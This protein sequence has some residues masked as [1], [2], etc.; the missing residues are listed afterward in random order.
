MRFGKLTR[1]H[2]HTHFF[3]QLSQWFELELPLLPV[4]I[5]ESSLE[6]AFQPIFLWMETGIGARG[7]ANGGNNCESVSVKVCAAVDSGSPLQ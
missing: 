2:T 4:V 6:E 5:P 3:A 1:R 7:F